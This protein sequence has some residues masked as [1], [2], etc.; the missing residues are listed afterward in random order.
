MNEEF[1]HDIVFYEDKDGQS[2]IYDFIE[3]LSKRSDKSSRINL[4]KIQ[5]Y[6]LML[7]QYGKTAGEPY[8]KHIDGDIWEIRPIRTRIFFAS[9]VGNDF[10][11]LHHFENKSTDKTPKKEI[12]KA[13]RNLADIRER[14]GIK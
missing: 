12:D 1:K 8:M 10:I 9:W 14:S 7:R 11:L 3:A 4:T 5:D 2:P 13:K 6:M